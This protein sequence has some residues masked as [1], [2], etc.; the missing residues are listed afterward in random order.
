MTTS[1]SYLEQLLSK[2]YAKGFCENN[3]KDDDDYLGSE[4]ERD[5][6]QF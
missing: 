3:Q 2:S 5:S 1:K 6:V 4:R